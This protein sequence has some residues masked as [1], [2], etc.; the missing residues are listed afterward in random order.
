MG[1][2]TLKIAHLQREFERHLTDE[3][4]MSWADA[5]QVEEPCFIQA[6]LIRCESCRQDLIGL[7]AF[8][9]KLKSVRPSKLR[10]G[11]S[12]L[13]VLFSGLQKLYRAVK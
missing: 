10:L 7:N 8:Q 13:A 12:S 2:L 3:E 1:I 6:H 5:E 9:A 11:W 4:L